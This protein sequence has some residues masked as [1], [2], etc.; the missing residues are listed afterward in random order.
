M[1][2][3]TKQKHLNPILI[4]R[5]D[6]PSAHAIMSNSPVRDRRGLIGGLST[7]SV[8]RHHPRDLFNRDPRQVDWVG[9]HHIWGLSQLLSRYD[10]KYLILKHVDARDPHGK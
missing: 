6:I 4:S 9:L 3:R 10:T 5:V 7:L 8:I 1:K 2:N